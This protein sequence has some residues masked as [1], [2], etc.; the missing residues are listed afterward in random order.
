[1]PST[2]RA[3]Q[4]PRAVDPAIAEQV[5]KTI[6]GL[7]M[8][9]VQQANSGHPGMPMGCADLATVLWT[10]FLVHDPSDPEWFDRD[11]FVLSAGHGSMLIYALLHLTGY[12]LSLDELKNFRQWGAKTAGHPEYGHCPGVDVTTGPLGS[13]F[14][15]G[16]GM[17]LA[18]RFLATRYNVEGHSVIDHMTYG[19]V[20]DGDLM[21]GIAAEA[22][23]LAGH[24]GL[25]KLVYLYDDNQISID[26][27]TD[28]SFGEDVAKRFEAYGWHVL[29]VDGHDHAA[30]RGAIEAGRAKLD[31]PT[32][33]C[34]RTVIG[35]GAPTKAGKSASH[36]A[37]LGPDEVAGAKQAMGWPEQPFHIPGSVSE[38]F[39]GQTVA[40]G[41]NKADWGARMNAYREAQPERAAELD[42]LIRGE[43]PAGTLEALDGVSA[44][45]ELGASLATR[46]ASQ[47]AIKAIAAV[48]PT[49]LGGS[50]DL[51]GSNGAK[52]PDSPGQSKQAPE[53]RNIHFGVREHGMAAICNGMALHGGV[54]CFDATFLVF[55][56][57][58]RG[59][60][61]L[62]ALMGL[63]VVHVFTHDS[64]FLGED[65]PTHQPIEH[66]MSLRA[67]PNLHVIRPGDARETVGAWKLALTRTD[68]PTALL[69]TRQGLTIDASTEADAVAKGA[70]VVREGA[71][72]VGALDGI[73]IATGSE[74][75]L[76]CEAAAKLAEAGKAIR[77]VS[78]PCWEAFA[79]QD[80]AYRESVLPR[81]VGRE[82]R[83]ALE[84]G[85]TLGWE[86]YADH[87][88]G[89]DHF[90]AS[91]PA[92]VLAEKFG[93]TVDAVVARWA[94]ITG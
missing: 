5:A 71:R 85:A 9:A 44:G 86:R 52:L 53:G 32:L 72:E 90:G 7:A 67:M 31:Q 62:S 80:A 45:F 74:L 24:L 64:F 38:F 84:A 20:S 21:E 1:M 27:G 50:A 4:R 59:A 12:D 63:P 23:S 41:Q 81:A 65:G 76:A 18:E 55:S 57:F 93:F 33:I 66:A 2:P 60:L 77:V 42:A 69:L 82:R 14:A 17:A 94:A 75:G 29:R 28:L 22:A 89:I 49:F 73:F 87:T 36:G 3:E 19:V 61:R 11:R 88:V 34:C 47:A 92:K 83:L 25:G 46:K 8:D 35:Q 48:H 68:G 43:L 58:M 79:A 39:G 30:V 15:S 54:R 10:E 26:G 13:G 56:D 6:K 91:A 37:P 78:M 51:A 40:H 16:V 70:Y